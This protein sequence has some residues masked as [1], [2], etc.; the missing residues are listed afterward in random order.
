MS[1]GAQASA[2]LSSPEC[3]GLQAA[4]G[5]P[6]PLQHPHITCLHV[7][8]TVEQQEL[9]SAA[10]RIKQGNGTWEST[11]VPSAFMLFT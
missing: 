4:R 9:P 1:Q 8:V 5:T 7:H 11:L 6:Y 2:C 10:V 3:H